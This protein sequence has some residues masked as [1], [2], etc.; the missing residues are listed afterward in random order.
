[1]SA[2]AQVLLR[3]LVEHA[4][5]RFEV[6]GIDSALVDAELLAGHILNLSRGGVQSEII[7][8]AEVSAEQ[9]EQITNLY[10]RRL[11]REPLQHITGTAYFR[12]LEL[13]V[14]RGVFIP[15]PG[16]E[17]VAQL[18]IDALRN[19][20]TPEPIGV[21]LGTGSGAIALAMATEVANSK[22]FAVEK[23]NDALPFTQKNFE[24]YGGSNAKLIHGDL[25]DAFAELD[26]E[27]SV[28]ASN[29]PYIPSAA[30]PRDIEVKLYD[31][32]LA[33]YGGEDGMQVMHRV[34]ATAKRLLRS[35]GF[36]VVEHADSQG[37]QVSEL[38]LADGWRQV[39][40]HK[41]LT[42]RDRAV[43]AIK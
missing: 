24:K 40:S 34:S 41:D 11:N 5:K 8:G 13:S 27:V 25:A 42:G 43:T 23:S 14:G 1:M 32:Q 4:A 28:V 17:F 29:P 26:G 10:G 3:D 37:Q 12:N 36:L 31:P 6:A 30:I 7:R 19:D 38:L 39:R 15:R 2:Q 9:A 21:D 35:G 20:A 33:L 22:I 16:T 18:A